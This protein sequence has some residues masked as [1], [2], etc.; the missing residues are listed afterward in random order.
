MDLDALIEQLNSVDSEAIRWQALA[1]STGNQAG[2]SPIEHRP[3]D[4][5][6]GAEAGPAGATDLPHWVIDAALLARLQA[7]LGLSD[8]DQERDRITTILNEAL[9]SWLQEQLDR[10]QTTTLP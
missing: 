2:A 8:P 10:A 4:P 1:A 5:P 3:S 6:Q 9:E 7:H